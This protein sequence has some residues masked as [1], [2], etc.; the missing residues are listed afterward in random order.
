[1]SSSAIKNPVF[2]AQYIAPTYGE[3]PLTLVKGQGSWVWDD[4]G[5]EFLDFTGGIAV[6]ALGHAHPV[7][8]RA[9]QRQSE[10]LI[11]VSNLFYNEPQL[12]LAQKL[13]N[14]TGP[15]SVFFCN[16]GAEANEVLIKLARKTGANSG[17]SEIITADGSF[18]GRTYGGISATGQQKV[19]TGFEPLLPGFKHVPFNNLG[20]VERAINE[21][22]AAVMIEGIQGEAGIIP[23]SSEYLVGLRKLTHDKNCLLLWDG[24]QC[25]AFRTGT[26]QSY[27]RILEE[28]PAAANFYPDAIAMAK[29]MGG[30]MPVGA[31]WIHEDLKD[32][33]GPGSHGSTY[34]GNPL[35]CS[36]ALAVFHEIEEKALN[37]NIRNIGDFLVSE[38]T[39]L[40]DHGK[41]QDVR[42][43]GGLIGMEVL[44]DAAEL[45]SRLLSKGL[46]LAPAGRNTLRWLPPFNVSQNEIEQGLGKLRKVL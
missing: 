31:V 21:K 37:K 17:N 1:M 12:K 18:H 46:L 2:G 39:S 30:G 7:I 22:T 23:A 24:V 9:L 45:R 44:G 16:S 14:L 6:N 28:N 5:N 27:E 40:K 29:S 35:A 26:F 34:G 13:V 36:V 25:G 11:H 20:A 8:Q 19:K 41:I 38:L 32:I 42:G 15:G 10:K 33:L 4:S 3:R 43:F